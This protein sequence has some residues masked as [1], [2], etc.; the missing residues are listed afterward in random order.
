M[1]STRQFAAALRQ[2]NDAQRAAV[3]QIEGPVLVIA[4]PGTGKTHI[5]TARIGKILLETDTQASNILCLTFTDAGVQAMRER[6]LEFIG[7]EAYRVHIFTFHSFCNRIIQENLE[8]F[9]QHELQPISELEQVELIHD[10]LEQLPPDHLLRRGKSTVYFYERHLR[11]LFSQMKRESWTVDFVR[12]RTAEYLAD[13]PEREEYYYQRKQGGYVK[14]DLKEAKLKEE[15][16]RMARL[17]AAVELYP[18]YLAR[19]QAAQRYDYDDML[20]MVLRAF[21]EQEYLLR[22]YQEQ[23]LYFLVDEFQDTNGAQNQLVQQ[24]IEYWDAPNIFVVGDDDQSIYEFQG[25]RLRNLSE[26]YE[27]HQPELSL[28]ML[29]ENYRSSQTILDGARRVIDRNEKRIVNNLSELGID[30]VLTAKGKVTQR[31]NTPPRILEYPNRTQEVVGLVEELKRLQVE[32]FPLEDVAVIY[33]RHK[34]ARELV[35]LLDKSEIP[36]HTKRRINVLDLPVVQQLRTLLE[37]LQ[38]EFQQPFSGEPLLYRILHYQFL[39]ISPADLANLS[40]A[41]AQIPPGD[42][43]PWRQL[44]NNPDM[45]DAR[46][47]DPGA[48]QG[49]GQLVEQLLATYNSLAAP[50]L[51]ER[52]LNRSG[53]LRHVLQLPDKDWWLQVLHTFSSFVQKEALRNQRLT[54]GRLLE[55]LRSMDRNRLALHVSRAGRQQ[56]GVELVTAHSAKGLEFDRVY[57]LDCVRDGW[58]PKSRTGSYRFSLPDTLTYSGEEDA[59]EARRRLFYVAMTRAK[60]YLQLSYARTN[61]KG[62]EIER[63]LYLDEVLADSELEVLPTTVPEALVLEAQLALLTEVTEPRLLTPPRSVL[64]NLLRHYRLSISALNQFLDCPLGFYYVHVLRVPTV[65]SEAATYGTAMHNALQRLFEVMTAS[66]PRAFPPA[67]VL[68]DYFETE[69][70][71]MRAHFGSREYARRLEAGRQYL[72]RYYDQHAADWPLRVQVERTIS[73]VEVNGVPIKGTIDRLD[74]YP[75]QRVHIVDYKTGGQ[76]SSKVRSP[77]KTGSKYELGGPYWRQLIFYRMLF[78]RQQPEARVRSAEISYLEPDAS[79]EFVRQVIEPTPQDVAF[80]REL[81]VT[82][83]GRIRRH[84][85]FDGCGQEDCVWCNFVREHVPVDSFSRPEIEALDD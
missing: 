22:T 7:P 11:E 21:K 35:D 31:L 39:G 18:A 13:L 72:Q 82:T 58:E 55:V 51:I 61:E 10:I 79:G 71:R 69:M 9:G 64:Q 42:R 41:Q 57:M 23:Y 67:Y 25:A 77:G 56:E 34:Q 81:L 68:L 59:M 26:F 48:L 17:L 70:E 38:L 3:E 73:N 52:V 74:F 33:A 6:L 60:S 27:R 46:V 8:L 85:F 53:L 1:K 65:M 12:A 62:K 63:S 66:E 16:Q 29:Q 24:L 14:G 44:I 5:L 75:E 45:I 54:P 80:V 84:D 2:L 43:I 47:T 4:G 36:Y 30:K 28:V 83:H 19:M 20:L 37:Y 49:F 32:D 40:L 78:E 50:R 76:S 15:Q